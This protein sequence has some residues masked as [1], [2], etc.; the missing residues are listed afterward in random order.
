MS[1]PTPAL[2][3]VLGSGPLGRAVARALVERGLTVRLVSRSVAEAPA[4]VQ[5]VAADLM[6]PGAIDAATA[7]AEA[8]YFCAQPPY[9]LWTRDFIPLQRAAIAAAER[10]GARLIVAEN[11]YAYGPVNAPMTEDLTPRPNTRKGAV[12]AEM[13]RELM[14][15]HDQGRVRVAVGRGSDFFGAEVDGSAVGARAFDA[16]EAGKPVAVLGDPDTPHSY[17]YVDDFGRALAVLGTDDRAL[18][19][20]WHVPN[21]PAVSTRRFFEIAARLAGVTPRIRKMSALELSIAGL[22]IPAVRETVE[23]IYEFERPFVADHGRFVAAFGD[24]S[25]PLEAALAQTLEGRGRGPDRLRPA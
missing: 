21:A 1:T 13:H 19:K 4:G 25:T 11:L 24:L 5:A 7:G 20:A 17:T 14:Q 22:F 2:H 12:R 10:V 8:L 23:M 15:A 3:V 9:H 16:L 6:N 18:G